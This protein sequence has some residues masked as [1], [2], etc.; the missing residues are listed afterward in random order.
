MHTN[1]SVAAPRPRTVGRRAVMAAVVPALAAAAV[2]TPAAVS[3]NAAHA[4]APSE[5]RTYGAIVNGRSWLQGDGVAVMRGRQ[6][7]ELATRLYGKKGWGSLNNIYGL[8]SGRTYSNGKIQIHRNGSGYV[9]VPGDVVV[10]LGGPYQHV[11]VVNKVTKRGVY[12]VE[13]NATASGRHLYG[14]SNFK[15]KKAT[16]AYHGRYVGY[17]IH[18]KKNHHKNLNKI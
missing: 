15:K 9:P 16:G 10:E 17:F 3:T 7:V 11:A 18:S 12:T 8:R 5:S 14:W 6:C 1:N 4:A 2:I 13:Q